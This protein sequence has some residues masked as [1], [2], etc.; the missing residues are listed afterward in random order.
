MYPNL[1]AEM[2]RKGITQ[3]DMVKDLNSRDCKISVTT[4]C[5]KM[6]GKREFTFA[7]AIAIKDILGVYVPLEVLFQRNAG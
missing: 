2:R 3:R 6:T 1:R 4:L 5:N 7:E